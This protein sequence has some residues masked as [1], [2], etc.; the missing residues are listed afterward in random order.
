MRWCDGSDIGHGAI[1][2]LKS[3]YSVFQKWTGQ[4]RRTPE[5]RRVSATPRDSIRQVREYLIV[6][7][8]NIG[9]GHDA[10]WVIV[11]ID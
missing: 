5:S 6:G 7:L 11:E 1:G 2:M 8:P 4:Q 9:C 10:I 3:T